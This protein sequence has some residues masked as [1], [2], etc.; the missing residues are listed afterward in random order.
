MRKI[1]SQMMI[2]LD[3]FIEGLN[4]ELNWHHVD[5]EYH[6]YTEE[7]LYS[8]DA[9]LYGRKTYQHM[10]NFWPTEFAIEKFPAI[11][12]RMNNLPK[13]VFSS[14][15]NDVDWNDTTLIKEKV[16]DYL[17]ELKQQP[18]KDL[19][20]LGSSDFVSFLTNINLVDEYQVIVNPVILGGGKPYFKNITDCKLLKL[21]RAKVFKSGNVLLCYQIARVTP[22]TKTDSK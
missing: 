21:V 8:V 12:E 1:I 9:I 5:D 20:I 13:I 22:Q 17:M 7:M 6:K 15:L 18:G 19:V 4:Q 11:A 10:K 3:G 2:S 14:T 16:N